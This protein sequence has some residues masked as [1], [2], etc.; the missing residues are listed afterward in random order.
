MLPVRV[1]TH[2]QVPQQHHRQ[3]KDEAYGFLADFHAGPHVLNPLSTEDAEDDKEG[4]EE[5]IHVPAWP[6]LIGCR[7]NV[8]L[9]TVAV[10]EELL[11]N[12]SEDKDNNGQDDS[13]VP[14]SPH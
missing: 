14:Q 12:Q 10:P 1:S 13:E 2:H 11:A 6:F 4:V 3:E 8:P 9:V 5:V 7:D